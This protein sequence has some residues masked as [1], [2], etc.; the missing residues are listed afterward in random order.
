MADSNERVRRRVMG[1]L[2][3]LLFYIASQARFSQHFSVT[4]DVHNTE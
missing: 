1:T 3:E 2:G 4:S